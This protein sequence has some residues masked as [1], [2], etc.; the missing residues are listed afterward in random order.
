MNCALMVI[1]F[2]KAFYKG[3]TKEFMDSASE[4]INAVLPFFRQS[5]SP[6]IW[7]QHKN[8]KEGLKPGAKDFELID[9]LKPERGEPVIYKE[10]E[11]SFNKT[12]CHKILKESKTDL[13]VL[14]GY[15]A[16]HCVLSTYRGA[17]DLD[18]LPVILK[19]GIA[20]GKEENKE[21]IEKISNVISCEILKKLLSEKK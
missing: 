6:V 8:E 18:L 9:K 17:E 21:F 4:Y 13:V 3:C 20:S 16:E 5:N 15:C 11:N 7:V 2:Q 12:D 14:T 1:D 19:D 10:Y